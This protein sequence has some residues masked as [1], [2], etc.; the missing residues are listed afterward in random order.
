MIVPIAFRPRI[1]HLEMCPFAVCPLPR[2]AAGTYLESVS[3]SRL[4]SASFPLCPLPQA[5]QHS[6]ELLEL[7]A[8]TSFLLLVPAA[9]QVCSIRQTEESTAPNDCLRLPVQIFEMVHMMTYQRPFVSRYS[10]IS[11]ILETD[12]IMAQHA[13]REVSHRSHRGHRGG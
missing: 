9:D 2:L 12:T 7:S 8:S 3:V 10:R 11:S 5:V 6:S 1:C 13:H 4:T